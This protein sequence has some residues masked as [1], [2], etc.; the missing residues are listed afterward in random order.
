MKPAIELSKP[1][2]FGE[3]VNDTFT[4]IKQNFK[5]LIKCFFTFCGFFLLVGAVFSCLQQ[6]QTIDALNSA[7]A[8]GTETA[9]GFS[10]L[11][12]LGLDYLLAMAFL[13]LTIATAEITVFCY[14]SLYK[15]KGNVPPAV[16][17]VWGYMKYYFM[18]S[19]T[20]LILIYIMLVIGFVL[21]LVP[22]LWLYPIFALIL[23]VMIFENTT[24]GYAF[25]HCFRL[26]KDFWW[27]TFGAI[28]ISG[29]IGILCAGVVAMPASLANMIVMLVNIKR[30]VRFSVGLTIAAS[31]LQHLAY[32]FY[33]IPMIAT[34][35][36]YFNLTEVKEGTSILNRIEG[37]GKEELPGTDLSEE[38]Y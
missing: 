20:A 33:I 4:F 9:T 29:I 23:P 26:I 32:V 28:V 5:P 27:V 34:A 17:E 38:Q 6:V 3:I 31:V 24:F 14:L 36:C 15:E 19:F 8:Y 10:G 7:N 18:R 21:C 35:L 2:D 30:G 1:R 25:S 22:G 37:F 12:T 11:R 16:A 13:F